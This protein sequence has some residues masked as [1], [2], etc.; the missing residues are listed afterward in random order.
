[1]RRSPR[2]PT[3]LK[4]ERCSC[5][6]YFLPELQSFFLMH[7][8]CF[9]VNSYLALF[10]AAIKY[11]ASARN[12]EVT[13][14][15]LN[16]EL[17][18]SEVGLIITR[19]SSRNMMM[20]Q[21]QSGF[22]LKIFLPGVSIMALKLTRLS[23]DCQ[24]EI[25]WWFKHSWVF[26]FLFTWFQALVRLHQLAILDNRLVVEYARPEHAEEEI[27]TRSVCLC[28]VC[29]HCLCCCYCRWMYSFVWCLCEEWACE[30]HGKVP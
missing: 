6:V 23:L 27:K 7:I 20:V 2:F 30:N 28:F 15:C 9:H 8:H 1:M 14:S 25:W 29:F 3:L 18:S 19:F 10:K 22:F 13:V 21:A 12:V 4:Q 24:V 26:F 5:P 16:S 11:V 17:R